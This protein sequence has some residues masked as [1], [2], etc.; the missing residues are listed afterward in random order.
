MMGKKSGVTTKLLIKQRQALV[1]HCQGHS[2]SLA[3]K[4]FT[5][6]YKILC[7]TMNTV[8]QIC[9]LGKYSSK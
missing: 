2:L 7:D 4:C 9:V 3:V 5:A 8:R 1:I 6:C